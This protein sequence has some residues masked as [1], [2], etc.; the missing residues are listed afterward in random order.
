VLEAP[1]RDTNA[2]AGHHDP[3]RRRTAAGDPRLGQ[4]LLPPESPESVLEVARL[5]ACSRRRVKTVL[6]CNR[7]LR[8]RLDKTI[9]PSALLWIVSSNDRARLKRFAHSGQSR[10]ASHRTS[11]WGCPR[12]WP[13]V[14]GEVF[15][16]EA[17][18]Q[19]LDR[20]LLGNFSPRACSM[21]GSSH[22][23]PANCHGF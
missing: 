7:S 5:Y 11:D 2:S 22:S 23:S 10:P 8:R 20:P 17:V 13:D 21:H 18:S 6:A 9:R 19:S 14:S 1:A 4:A 3:R 16:D 12:S 15:V